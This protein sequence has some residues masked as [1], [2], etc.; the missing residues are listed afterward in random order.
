MSNRP[1][2][3]LADLAVSPAHKA[4]ARKQLELLANQTSH[5][6]L[7]NLA[8]DVLSGRVSLRGAL[9]D[10]RATTVL[11]EQI[12]RFTEQYR[13]LSAEERAE[14]ERRAE[15]FAK[16]AQREEADV[17]TPR[18]SRPRSRADD[19]DHWENPPPILRKRR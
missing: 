2:D 12:G 1:F 5:P 13:E 3:P 18:R 4:G 8:R 19:E 17:A 15:D 7:R 16:E 11:D 6:E 14:H 9:N 10:P